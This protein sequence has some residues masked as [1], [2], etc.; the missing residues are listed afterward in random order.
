MKKS[1]FN[2]VALTTTIC[3][4][5]F[6]SCKKELPMNAPATSVSENTE[7]LGQRHQLSRQVEKIASDLSSFLARK[8]NRKLLLSQ[9]KTAGKTSTIELGEVLSTVRGQARQTGTD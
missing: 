6:V 7:S 1:F 3:S 8:E 2:K 4:L 5:L 9:M